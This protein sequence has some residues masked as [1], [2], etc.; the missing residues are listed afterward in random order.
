MITVDI[1]FLVVVVVAGI[2]TVVVAQDA[3]VVAQDAVAVAV[4]VALLMCSAKFVTNLD[5]VHHFVIIVL[6]RTMFHSS[7]TCCCTSYFNTICSMGFF[8]SALT[9]SSV[10][11]TY[12]V[13]SSIFTVWLFSDIYCCCSTSIHLHSTTTISQSSCFQT[14]SYSA[15]GFSG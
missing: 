6:K 11:P 15:S 7:S 2:T 14:A 5:K 4:E 10:C 13:H 8:C 1:N 9:A 12:S 3:M